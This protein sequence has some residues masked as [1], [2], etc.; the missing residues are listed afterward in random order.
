VQIADRATLL[1]LD[2]RGNNRM[3]SLRN[4]LAD[5][6][7]SLM[8]IVRGSNNVVRVNGTA[9]VTSA[10]DMLARF[11]DR[12]RHPRSVVVVHVAEVYSQ[13]A[14][15]LMRAGVWLASMMPVTF[16]QSE[17]FWPRLRL[18]LMVRP[19]MT[20]GR[21]APK[22]QCGNEESENAICNDPSGIGHAI[23]PRAKHDRTGRNIRL[24]LGL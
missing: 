23:C 15:A 17:S 18:D 11:D 3:D 13:C 22:R 14:R 4:I 1:M 24:W 5:G 16:P 2:W 9:D 12:G 21:P 6:R 20:L 8:F 10:P 19:M 7:V